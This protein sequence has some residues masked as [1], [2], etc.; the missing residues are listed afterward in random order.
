M[1]TPARR[2]VILSIMRTG[3]NLLEQMLNSI[4]GVTCHGELL[5]QP[6]GVNSSVRHLVE[7]DHPVVRPSLRVEKPR[8]YLDAILDR[9]PAEHVGFRI[10]PDHHNPILKSLVEDPTV[11]KIILTRDLLESY[12]SLQI[13]QQNNQW[14]MNHAGTRKPW[15]PITIEMG[16]FKNYALKNAAY[17]YH[18]ISRCHQT[19]Q[20]T[21]PIEYNQINDPATLHR[22]LAY[23]GP[24]RAVHS[25]KVTALRQNPEPLEQKIKNYSEVMKVIKRIRLDDW[26]FD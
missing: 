10:F 2:F 24:D 23:F 14:I 5:N 8:E 3:S 9:T 22:L 25:E 12:T 1:P 7:G 21:T 26:L 13:A 19:G 6:N 20:H 11:H 15:A 18:I 16:D 4:E 17:Y